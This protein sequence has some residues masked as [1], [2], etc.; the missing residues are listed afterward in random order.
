MEQKPP[1]NKNVFYS[2]FKMPYRK[3]WTDLKRAIK[4][5]CET[6]VVTANRQASSINHC[7]FFFTP[8]TNLTKATSKLR[9]EVNY[10]DEE[11]SSNW[12]E[13]AVQA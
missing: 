12:A 1:K 6:K 3:S 10:V 9:L 7:H 5:E 13:K 2:S 11:R 4:K 8:S